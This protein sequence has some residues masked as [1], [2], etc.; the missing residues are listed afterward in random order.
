MVM[1][2]ALVL[3]MTMLPVAACGSAGTDTVGV[4]SAPPATQASPSPPDAREVPF[5]LLTHCGVID[6]RVEGGYWR[7]DPPLGNGNPPEGFGNPSTP[8]RWKQTSETTATFT[9]DTGA[10]ATFVRAEPPATRR[11]CD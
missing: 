4:A 10:T 11:L 5:T 1:R 8:G 2:T 9:A 3:L 6:A 7:A